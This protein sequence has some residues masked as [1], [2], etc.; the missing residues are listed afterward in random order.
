M[1]ELTSRD[2]IYIAAASTEGEVF[3][4]RTL[5]YVYAW[6]QDMGIDPIEAR[7][8]SLLFIKSKPVSIKSLPQQAIFCDEYKKAAKSLAEKGFIV[9]MP[10]GLYCVTEFNIE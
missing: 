8:F 2:I 4:N 10:N 1:E 7:V 9:E 3:S 5:R 6:F